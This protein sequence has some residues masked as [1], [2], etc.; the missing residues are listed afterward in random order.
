MR[1]ETALVP[2]NRNLRVHDH[3]ALTAAAK[4]KRTARIA[5]A[6]RA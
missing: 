3:P 2:F 4:A 1:I 6:E 5:R